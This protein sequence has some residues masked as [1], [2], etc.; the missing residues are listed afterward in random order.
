M[1]SGGVVRVFKT[2]WFERYARRER[3]GDQDLRDAI[4]RAERGLVDADLG[5]GVIKQRARGRG[6]VAQGAT[7]C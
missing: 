3:I 6:K 4:K 5:G 7:E 2:K 1:V